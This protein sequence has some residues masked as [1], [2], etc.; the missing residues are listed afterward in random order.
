MIVHHQRVDKSSINLNIILR[1]LKKY[2]IQFTFLSILL[3]VPLLLLFFKPAI[4]KINIIPKSITNSLKSS[5]YK[6]TTRPNHY[7]SLEVSFD[8]L[9]S[10]RDKRTQALQTGILLTSSDDFVPADIS[11]QDSTYAVDIR[12]KGDWLDQVQGDLWGLRI[13]TDNDQVI[14]GTDRFSLQPPG[15]RHYLN[16]WIFFEALKDEGVIALN[17]DFVHANINGEH[18]GIYAFEEHFTKYLLERNQ[19]RESP[20][21]K[22]NEDQLWQDTAV[23][24][25][26][27]DFGKS[28]RFINNE[29]VFAPV[30]SF[31]A[32]KIKSDP[33][34]SRL[35]ADASAKLYAVNQ[36]QLDPAEVF[37]IETWT[38]YLALADVFGSQHGLSWQNLRFYYNPLTAL[39]E[40]IPFDSMPGNITDHL[41]LERNGTDLLSLLMQ[42]T[43]FKTAYLQKLHQY[44][45]DSYLDSLISTYRKDLDYYQRL[46]RR[47]N[48]N[49]TF[50]PDVFYQNA[51][52]T[53]HLLENRQAIHVYLPSDNQEFINKLYINNLSHAPISLIKSLPDQAEIF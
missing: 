35:Y 38:S 49:Y 10:L 52:Y 12:L 3:I 20:I 13:K 26:M 1:L 53:R 43:K 51:A 17:Y 4:Q 47:D 40:P 33:E 31:R 19:R 22:F 11:Y 16:E 46:I 39:F 34:L 44:S 48:L 30:D 21:L 32:N 41:N 6:I 2:K 8:S 37:D 50:D 9:Q 28:N 29:L 42:N 24:I 23:M 36:N 27:G 5:Y 7:L 45:Q 25:S 15:S 18:K 14:F